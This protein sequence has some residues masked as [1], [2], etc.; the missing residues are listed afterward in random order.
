MW[1]NQCIRC[2]LA[3]VQGLLQHIEHEGRAHGAAH[4]PAHNAPGVH[5]D[6]EGHVQ[7]ALP[8]RDVGEV[9]DPQLIRM[10]SPEHPVDPRLGV[11][12]RRAYDLAPTHALDTQAPH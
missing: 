5:V 11:A 9:R 3:L 8:G 1:L 10:L 4:M 7:L 6:D 2:G 12:D